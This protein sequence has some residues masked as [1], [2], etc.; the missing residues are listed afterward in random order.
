[1]V[2]RF[3]LFDPVPRITQRIWF[4]NQW[5]I[6]DGDVISHK[7]L[8]YPNCL[9]SLHK[10]TPQDWN[11]L[12]AQEQEREQAELTGAYSI[13]FYELTTLISETIPTNDGANTTII[14]LADLTTLLKQALN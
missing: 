14:I 7:L 8:Y 12:K 4:S 3:R 13:F 11:Y 1:M 9:V 5:E 2:I 6:C 10:G